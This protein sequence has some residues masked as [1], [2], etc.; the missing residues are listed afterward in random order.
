MEEFVAAIRPPR[1]VIIMVKAGKPVDEQIA[2]LRGVLSTND[3]IIDA[4]NANF[5]DTM[6][7]FH[8]LARHRPDLH[9]HG[10]VRRRGGRAPW[11]VDHGRRHRKSPGKRV[12]KVLTA[13]SAKFKGEPCC[14]WL[15]ANGAGHFVKTIHNGIEYADMQM[16]A[17]I[18]GILRDGLGME[19]KEIGEVFGELE[20]GPA[21][22]LSDRD[23]RQG[24]GRR[25]SEDR[26][27]RWSMSSSTAPARR[28]PAN[29][30]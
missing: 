8:E 21:Q 6:R 1:P 14:A 11:P 27:S 9:R 29:G 19:P 2:A 20:Q 4:G 25:R 30:R 3:I 28:A 24:A 17:E 16:I 7:R 22:F 13:I 5:R 10:R 12:E 15:G 26:A 18:Y 23:H